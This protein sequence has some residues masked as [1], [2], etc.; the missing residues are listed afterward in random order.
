[1]ANPLDEMAERSRHERFFFGCLLEQYA[2]VEGLDDAAL[3]ANL[4]CTVDDLRGLR[5]CRAPRDDRAGLREDIGRVAAALGLNEGKLTRV[6]VRARAT[7]MLRGKGG[8][9]RAA[10]DRDED[11]T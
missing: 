4:G 1:M 9:L 5:L 2:V 11:P 10:R 8:S 3:A 6:V 7:A